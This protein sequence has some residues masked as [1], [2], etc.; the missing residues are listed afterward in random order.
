MIDPVQVILLVIIVLLSILLLVLGIQ[1]FFILK[2]LRLT[3]NRATRVLENTE[4]ITESISEPMSLF[5]NL[6]LSAKSISSIAKILKAFRDKDG[7]TA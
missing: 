6:V 3:I 5:S 2:E 1:V 7:D 4:N